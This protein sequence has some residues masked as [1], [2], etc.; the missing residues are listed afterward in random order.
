MV[1]YRSTDSIRRKKFVSYFGD[2]PPLRQL[3]N[4]Q[5]LS[6][7]Q[8]I[9]WSD[10]T[11]LNFN[12]STFNH[13]DE[14]FSTNIVTFYRKN[15]TF[16][17]QEF[18]TVQNVYWILTSNILK[19]TKLF[20]CNSNILSDNHMYP[21]SMA[22]QSNRRVIRLTRSLDVVIVSKMNVHKY[23]FNVTMNMTI[24]H[25]MMHV[26]MMRDDGVFTSLNVAGI[27]Q[28]CWHLI[29]VRSWYVYVR[30]FDELTFCCLYLLLIVHCCRL[31]C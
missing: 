13:L 2:L 15:R 17:R 25:M 5:G 11:K 21:Y 27:T 30:A 12:F 19:I 9:H 6:C 10:N 3:L 18:A 20:L 14:R 23:R 8:H 1:K 4:G 7:R 16:W 28:C 24:W 26:M 29:L 31:D 22:D